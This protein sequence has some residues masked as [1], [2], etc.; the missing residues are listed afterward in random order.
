[1]HHSAAAAALDRGRVDHRH[2]L[3]DQDFRRNLRAQWHRAQHPLNHHGGL[4]H[5]ICQRRLPAWHAAGVPTHRYHRG[6]GGGL[7]ARLREVEDMTRSRAARFV[8]TVAIAAIILWS[9]APIA[10]G[11]VTSVS[12]QAD[13]QAVPP[14]WLPDHVTMD[15]YRGLLGG[16]ADIRVGG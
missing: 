16:T 3:G 8:R 4:Y 10:L 7:C 2:S 5:H 12:T 13:V 6:V 1:P 9:L 15:P 11:V 14:H